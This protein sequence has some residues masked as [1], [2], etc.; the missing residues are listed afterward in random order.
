M[1]LYITTMSFNATYSNHCSKNREKPI[2]AIDRRTDDP[3]IPYVEP[4]FDFERMKT[5]PALSTL[6]YIGMK[7]AGKRARYKGP[8]HIVLD[9]AMGTDD[10]DISE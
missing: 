8:F 9:P 5:P 4:K 3:D 1:H 6:G 7:K 2:S 10:V